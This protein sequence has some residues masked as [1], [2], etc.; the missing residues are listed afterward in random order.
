MLRLPFRQ[1]R[2]G[3]VITGSIDCGESIVN[4][5]HCGRS[6]GRSR[7]YYYRHFLDMVVLH[8]EEEAGMG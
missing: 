7:L 6:G 5:R 1:M 4:A 3:R 2:Q 8:T